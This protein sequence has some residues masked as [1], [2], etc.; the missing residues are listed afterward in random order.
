MDPNEL[1]QQTRDALTVK[2]VFGEPYERN[3][4]TVIPVAALKGGGGGGSG[5]GG[6]GEAKGGGSGGGFGLTARPAGV[7][8]I[9]SNKVR[10]QPAVDANRVIV[11]A[12]IVAVV[13]LL[14]FRSV[15]RRKR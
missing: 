4:L 2:R 14:V 11:G 1:M 5:E 10:W 9:E 3:G 8:I 12:Q 7:Y 13:A 15:R 6:A